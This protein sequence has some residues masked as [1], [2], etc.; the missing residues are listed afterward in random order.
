MK[1]ADFI[2]KII[3]FSIAFFIFDKLFYI[4][5]LLSPNLEADKR[6][7]KLVTGNINKEIIIIGSSRGA[8]N[9]IAKQIEDSLHLT[10]F[11]LSYP[12]SDID[13]QNFILKTLLKFNKTPKII[14]LSL[15][16]PIEFKKNDFLNFRLDRLYPLARFNYI[17]DEMI[18]RGEKNFLSQ[19]LVLS[20]INKVNFDLRKKKFNEFDTVRSNGS[21]PISFTKQNSDLTFNTIKQ[22]YT[23]EEELNIKIDSFLEF[24][25]L[26]AENNIEL[27][28]IFPPNF[29]IINNQFEKRIKELTEKNVYTYIYDSTNNIYKDKLYYYDKNHLKENGAIVFTNEIID[30]LSRTNIIKELDK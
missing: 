28:L 20:R 8:R 26:C 27:I 14:L 25:K 15:D 21:M 6:L 16:D 5:L 17:N 7:E 10:S 1:R 2:K 30:F 23:S 29:Q 4:F 18:R 13:F 12:G 22:Q 24:Q 19:F 9:L 3:F 11:N